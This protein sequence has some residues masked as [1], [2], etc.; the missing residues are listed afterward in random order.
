MKIK[1]YLT[2][3]GN[4]QEVA[5]KY[6]EI[7]GGRI[8]NLTLYG[9]CVPDVAEEHKSRIAHLCLIIGDQTIG[10]ADSC[11]QQPT[12]FG[13]GNVITVHCDSEEQI[14]SIYQ[15]LSAGGTINCPLQ[16]TF[17][18]KQYAEF[19]DCYGVA[20]CLIIE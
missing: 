12:T 15:A 4:A 9:D 10:I 8:E 14:K 6:A 1:P 11:P 16:A 19:V 13:T 3:N 7:L 2:F 17:F 20:W 5:K 18:A